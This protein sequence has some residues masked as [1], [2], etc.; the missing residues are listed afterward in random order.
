MFHVHRRN[1][2][3][4]EEQENET[5]FGQKFRGVKSR[6]DEASISIKN[7]SRALPYEVGKMD[8]LPAS[9]AR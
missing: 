4:N 2:G 8:G 5:G 9:F 3:K 7:L 1:G 6:P